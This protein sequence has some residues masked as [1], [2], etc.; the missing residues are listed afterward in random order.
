MDINLKHATHKGH[1][2]KKAQLVA[3]YSWP[4]AGKPDMDK[5]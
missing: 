4:A 2:W 3:Q 1:M 5:N